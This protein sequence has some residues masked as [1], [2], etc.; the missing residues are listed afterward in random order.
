MS[1]KSAWSGLGGDEAAVARAGVA[2]D[3]AVGEEEGVAAGPDAEVAPEVEGGA[4]G[5]G[6]EAALAALPADFEHGTAVMAADPF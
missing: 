3:G 5:V 2:G 1:S 6:V 4:G